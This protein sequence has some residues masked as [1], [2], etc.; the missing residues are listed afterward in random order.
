M[1]LTLELVAD[2]FFLVL[3]LAYGA[4]ALSLPEAMFGDPWEPRIYPLIIAASMSILSIVLIVTEIRRQR[5]GKKE[6][7]VSFA[8]TSDGKIVAFVVIASLIYTFLF[9]FLGYA[10]STFLFLEIIMLYVSKAKKML[11]PTIIALTFSIGI[12]FIFSRLLSITLP[13]GRIFDLIG[14]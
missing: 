12:Y 14:G 3:A 4:G 9:D 13:P 7:P 5:H 10:I 6:K 8:I 1:T 2:L 11:W